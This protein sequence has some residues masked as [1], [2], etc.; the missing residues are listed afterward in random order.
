M[1]PN[2]QIKENNNQFLSAFQCLFLNTAPKPTATVSRA[3]CLKIQDI[4]SIFQGKM[5]AEF[6]CFLFLAYSLGLILMDKSCIIKKIRQERRK[7]LV[8]LSQRS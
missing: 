6:H 2:I 7:P 3:I 4:L 1:G 8:R 5:R